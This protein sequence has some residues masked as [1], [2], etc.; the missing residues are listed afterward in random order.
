MKRTRRGRARR[1]GVTLIEILVVLAVL[2]IAL[3]L[4]GFLGRGIAQRASERSA[5]NSLQQAVWQGATLAAARG[6]RTELV[7]VG[8]ELQVR[9]L[10][11]GSVLRRFELEPSVTLNFDGQVL[12]FT[13]P[14]T[15]TPE[16]LTALASLPGGG[17]RV[18]AAGATYGFVVS[19]IGE[20]V[21]Q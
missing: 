5:V 13:P 9:R 15:I 19:L 3:G 2:G 10:A 17:L 4:A 8:N 18:T 16:S 21:V 12:V 7:R 11:D 14:G 1:S 20:V 6:F